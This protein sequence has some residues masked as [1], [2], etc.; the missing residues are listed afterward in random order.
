VN[1]TEFVDIYNKIE[2]DG[3][4][5]IKQLIKRAWEAG[6]DYAWEHPKGDGD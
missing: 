3:Q 1:M 5:G 6:R 2:K 4:S